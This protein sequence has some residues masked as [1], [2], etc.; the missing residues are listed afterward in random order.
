M[1]DSVDS[2]PAVREGL[3][4][5]SDPAPTSITRMLNAWSQGDDQALGA[6][7]PLVYDELR[8]MARRHMRHEREGHTLQGTGL[9]HEAFMRL[10][11]GRSAQ[12][13]SRG[14]FFGWMSTLMRRTLVDHARR[15]HAAKRGDGQVLQSLD[16][17]QDNVGELPDP[18]SG[19]RLLDIVRLDEALTR[20]EALDPRQGRLVEL[21]F[22]GGLSVDEA[23]EA[24][25][26]SAAT[27]KREWSTA[28]AWLLR[29]LGPG[30][31]AADA[32]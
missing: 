19:E 2:L 7:V 5:D 27:V 8:R 3:A 25:Q 23:A 28:R 13:A 24:L 20:L 14:Q 16:A 30:A 9:V 1:N 4:P 17:L 21:R 26:V 10:A 31:A 6:L 32:G 18:G 22:F 12:W 15:R 11:E 29:E